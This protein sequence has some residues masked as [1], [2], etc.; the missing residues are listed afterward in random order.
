MAKRKTPED[1]YKENVRKQQKILE[2][3]AAHEMEWA[4]DLLVWYRHKKLDMPEDEYRG[5]SFFLN[6]EFSH[7]PGA[8]TLLYMMYLRLEK[9]LPETNKENAFDLLRFRYK[10]YAK[11]L[12]TGGYDNGTTNR[13]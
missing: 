2:E 7:K 3:F 12:K 9:E 8:L 6:K 1:R 4:N 5:C 11:L 10:T 13:G